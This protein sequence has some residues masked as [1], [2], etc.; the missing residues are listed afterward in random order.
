MQSFFSVEIVNISKYYA[1][2]SFSDSLKIPLKTKADLVLTPSNR[3]EP[4]Y[5][6]DSENNFVPSIKF[7]QSYQIRNEEIS[8][9][10][11]IKVEIDIPT[12]YAQKPIIKY[13]SSL[14]MM[15]N[16]ETPKPCEKISKIEAAGKSASPTFPTKINCLVPGTRC[17]HIRY[18]CNLPKEGCFPI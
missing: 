7:S 6:K 9:V 12:H 3:E 5:L 2:I 11:D 15:N 4:I 18:L 1:I 17:I 14:I 16:G 8:P 13:N 10:T